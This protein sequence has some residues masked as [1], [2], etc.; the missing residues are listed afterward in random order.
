MPL[1]CQPVCLPLLDQTPLCSVT[2][3]VADSTD[4]ADVA[5]TAETVIDVALWLST[6]IESGTPWSAAEAIERMSV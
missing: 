4:P 1:S 2:V 5:R 6:V 3:T